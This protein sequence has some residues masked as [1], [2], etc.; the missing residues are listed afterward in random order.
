MLDGI[1][2]EK[3]ER[4][5]REGRNRGERST[6]EG[7]GLE[8]KKLGQIVLGWSGKKKKEFEKVRESGKNTE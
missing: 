1:R 2:R 3:H 8:K 7:K 4:G 6:K 5:E